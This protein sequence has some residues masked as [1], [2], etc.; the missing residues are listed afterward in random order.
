M[1]DPGESLQFVPASTVAVHCLHRLLKGG[2]G[3]NIEWFPVL[4]PMKDTQLS[5]GRRI[6]A[7]DMSYACDS[8]LGFV[9]GVIIGLLY[10]FTLRRAKL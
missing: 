7:H 4:A 9:Q 8:Q 1:S 3:S 6:A 10:A 2:S 5:G